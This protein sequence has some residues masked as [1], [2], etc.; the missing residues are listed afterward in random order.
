MFREAERLRQQ[1]FQITEGESLGVVQMER[2]DQGHG[3]LARLRA[4]DLK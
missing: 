1:F 4:C 2:Q 3:S